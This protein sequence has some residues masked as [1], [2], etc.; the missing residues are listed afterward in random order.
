[1]DNNTDINKITLLL[2]IH[3]ARYYYLY[4]L[5]NKP[6]MDTICHINIPICLFVYLYMKTNYKVK[7][8]T[9]NYK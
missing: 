2:L 4:Y 1:M 9:V 6:I 7:I 5:I 3:K 8:I